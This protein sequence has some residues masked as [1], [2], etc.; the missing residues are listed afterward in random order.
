MNTAIK[1]LMELVETFSEELRAIPEAEFSAKPLPHKWSKKEVL[2]HLA[3]SGHNNLRRFI[4]GQHESTPPKIIYD[5]DAW[6]KSNNYQNETQVATIELWKM[7]NMRI[8]A[9]L[10]AMPKAHYAK[11]CDTGREQVQL[12]SLEWL[13][14]DYVKHMKHHLNQIIPGSFDVTYP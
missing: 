14:S 8:V 2:G 11:A 6:V 7:I 9:V 1:E 3:D 12:H 4:S 13:A 5:Q 10:A